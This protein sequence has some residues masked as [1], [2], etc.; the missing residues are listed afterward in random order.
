MIIEVTDMECRTI[1]AALQDGA[2]GIASLYQA[3]KAEI[4]PGA[5][6]AIVKS[7]QDMRKLAAR[8]ERA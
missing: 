4:V 8:L 1:V 2:D 7:I 6:D 5:H 3:N